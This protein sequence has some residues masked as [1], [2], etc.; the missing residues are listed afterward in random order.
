MTDNEL[1]QLMQIV[2]KKTALFPPLS[3][4]SDISAVLQQ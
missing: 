4:L 2:K 3:H 1:D